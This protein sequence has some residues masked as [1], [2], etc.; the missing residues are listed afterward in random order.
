MLSDC[1]KKWFLVRFLELESQLSTSG[2]IGTDG[3]KS[4]VKFLRSVFDFLGKTATASESLFQ[5]HII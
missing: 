2:V 5:V 1:K 3:A 4:P